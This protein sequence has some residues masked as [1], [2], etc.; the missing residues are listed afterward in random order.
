MEWLKSMLAEKTVFDNSNTEKEQKS[1]Q[2]I[3]RKKAEKNKTIVFTL[4]KIIYPYLKE[5]E[6][7]FSSQN[8]NKYNAKLEINDHLIQ[9]STYPIERLYLNIKE[10]NTGNLFTIEIEATD[11]DSTTLLLQTTIK[12]KAIPESEKNSLD[13][14]K[15]SSEE[16]ELILKKY[17]SKY[18]QN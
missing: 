8:K 6:K 1:L 3:S 14:S 10:N 16:F 12:N 9:P 13:C 5:I 4:E 15:F 2:E 18:L 11:D 7:E 17:I